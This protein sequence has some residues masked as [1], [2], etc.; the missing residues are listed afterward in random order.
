MKELYVML[1]TDGFDWLSLF[2]NADGW[3]NDKYPKICQFTEK[4]EGEGWERLVTSN[5]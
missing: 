2:R 1:E 5:M 3:D 4:V